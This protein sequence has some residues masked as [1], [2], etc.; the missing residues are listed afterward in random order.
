MRGIEI[1]DWVQDTHA[2]FLDSL[3]GLNCRYILTQSFSIV[4]KTEALTLIGRQLKQLRSTEDDGISQQDA[5]LLAKDELVSG[6][7]CFGDH[8]LP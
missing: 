5:L 7:V 2:G 6:N 1:K 3:I 4:P 8:H